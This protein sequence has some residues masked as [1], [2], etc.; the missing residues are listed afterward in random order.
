MTGIRLFASGSLAVGDLI[1]MGMGIYFSF[2]RPSLLPE[3]ARYMGATLGQIESAVPG[4]APWPARVFGVLGGFLFA[5]GLLTF[6]VAATNFRARRPGGAIAIVAIAGVTSIGWMAFTNFL[7][8]S[9]LKWLLLAF[10]LPWV[11]A[12]VLSW[13]SE[14]R[15]ASTRS[16]T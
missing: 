16:R 9:D 4:L 11:V 8:N 7:I 2:L 6:L 13:A 1:L 10:T 3:D 14:W 5:T 12:L 15:L